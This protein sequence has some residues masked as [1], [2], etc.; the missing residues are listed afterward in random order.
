MKTRYLIGKILLFIAVFSL[1]LLFPLFQKS[2]KEA[3]DFSAIPVFFISLSEFLSG[4]VVLL[5]CKRLYSVPI[6]MQYEKRFASS[7][8]LV[9]KSQNKKIRIFLFLKDA[10]DVFLCFGI[11]CVF[12]AVLQAIAFLQPNE[13]MTDI[14]FPTGFKWIVC[15]FTL[16]FSAF[17]EEALYRTFV[18]EYLLSIFTTDLKI[19]SAKTKKLS[20][21]LCESFAL[22]LFALSH[23]YLGVFSVINAAFAHIALRFFLKK[24]KNLFITVFAHFLYN[25]ISLLLIGA[26]L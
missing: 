23:R 13:K 14:V 17:Y 25:L 1:F 18:P 4:A 26:R 9:K 15:I 5:L 6:Y 22:L 21:I 3:M 11:L 12:S 16:F 2:T 19:N 10:G 24:D 7:A 8:S 20:C